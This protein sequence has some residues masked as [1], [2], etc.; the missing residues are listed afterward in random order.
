[1]TSPHLLDR[2]KLGSK[3]HV[4]SE[5]QGIP[6]VVA[7]AANTNDILTLKPLVTGMH[8]TVQMRS[9]QQTTCQAPG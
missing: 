6:L 9:P 4:L 7:A 8:S 2:G 5:G 3:P 1:M